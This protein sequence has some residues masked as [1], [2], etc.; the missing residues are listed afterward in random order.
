MRSELALRRSLIAEAGDGWRRP[1]VSEPGGK[2]CASGRELGS[3]AR[4]S[5]L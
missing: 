3:G 1:A 2:P 5:I 4:P